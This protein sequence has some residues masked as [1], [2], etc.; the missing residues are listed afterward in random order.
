[1]AFPK[2]TAYEREEFPQI[3][4]QNGTHKQRKRQ[5]LFLIA[6]APQ[7]TPIETRERDI[8]TKKRERHGENKKTEKAQRHFA[9][10]NNEQNRMI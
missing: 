5:D 10:V 7:S 1:M 9:C 4:D 8:T 2:K 6:C 3:G